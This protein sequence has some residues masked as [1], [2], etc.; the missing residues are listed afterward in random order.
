MTDWRSAVGERYGIEPTREAMVKLLVRLGWRGVIT[1]NTS[2]PWA[3]YT[4]RVPGAE[5]ITSTAETMEEAI[6]RALL[7]AHLSGLDRSR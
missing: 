6:G 2:E 5:E 1:V 3:R 4:L 7:K